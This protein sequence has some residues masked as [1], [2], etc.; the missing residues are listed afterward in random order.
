MGGINRPTAS[1]E[2]RDVLRAAWG[3][4]APGEVLLDSLLT[5]YATEGIFNG[6][7]LDGWDEGSDYQAAAAVRL[8]YYS[9]DEAVPLIAARLKGLDVMARP[10]GDGSMLRDIKNGV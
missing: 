10:K 9:P 5:D 4:K 6:S 7:S 3:G 1:H 2:S 8:L